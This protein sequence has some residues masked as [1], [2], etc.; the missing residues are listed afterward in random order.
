MNGQQDEGISVGLSGEG[1]VVVTVIMGAHYGA[2]S[3]TPHEARAV[4][5]ILSTAADAIDPGAAAATPSAL[6]ERPIQGRT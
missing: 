3:L 1:R 4:A 6:G 5:R 2:V